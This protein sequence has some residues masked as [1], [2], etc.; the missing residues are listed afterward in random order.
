MTGRRA[1]ADKAPKARRVRARVK[2]SGRPKTSRIET[3]LD[4]LEGSGLIHLAQMQPDL[5]YLF[6]HA[7]V[8]EAAYHSLLKGDRRAQHRRVGEVLER[9]YPDRLDELA[10]VLAL[11]FDEAGDDAR[12]LDYYMRAGDFALRRYANAEAVAHYTRALDTAGHIRAARALPLGHLFT[13]RGRALELGGQ[14]EQALANYQDM[15]TQA[16]ERGDRALEL[17]ALMARATIHSTPSAVHDPLRSKSLSEQALA[18]ARELGDR[19]AESKILWNLMLLSQFTGSMR[20]AVTYGEKSLALARELDLREQLAYTLND[21]VRA[22]VGVGQFARAWEVLDESRDIWRGLGNLPM[23]TDNLGRSA[24]IFFA[25]GEYDRAIAAADEAR[26]LSESIGNL[27]GQ[28]FC[29]MFVGMIY[30]ERGDPATAIVTMTDCI[31]LAAQAG[32]VMGLVGTRSDLAW[33]YG[34]LGATATGLDTGRLAQAIAEQRLPVFKPWALGGLA[35]LQV[36]HGDL[37]AAEASVAEAYSGLDLDDLSTHGAVHVPMADAELAL[38][39]H[40]HARAARVTDEL[41]AR[42][43]KVG[44][45]SFLADALFL[46]AKALLA[47]GQVEAAGRVLNAARAEAESLGSRWMLWQI[48]AA[49]SAVE[50]NRGRHAEVQAVRAQ[51]RELIA[52]IAGHM[53]TRDMRDAFLHRPTVRAIMDAA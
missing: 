28:A 45:R 30:F 7:L 19:Q 16:R 35:R 9:L 46:K 3:Q 41:I 37:A 52:Y 50:E 1:K 51:A 39:K 21:S 27:W 40:D 23:L 5:E 53:P 6:R 47:Q 11:H 36:M 4:A 20:D 17:A 31:R 18:L 25:V 2:S 12:A 22:Y 14:Y 44:M 48:L 49:L 32:L 38:A 42:L 29:R 10:P 33:I 13:Q 34:V 15:E 24:R 8:Q 26:R 43:R